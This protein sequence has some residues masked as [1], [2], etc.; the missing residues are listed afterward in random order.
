[1]KLAQ[2]NYARYLIW[3]MNQKINHN[4]TT[5]IP[6]TINMYGNDY[7]TFLYHFDYI[8]TSNLTTICDSPT[9]PE[10]VVHQKEKG[11]TLLPFNIKEWYR[12]QNQT[13]QCLKL[14]HHVPPDTNVILK[15]KICVE[16]GA[17]V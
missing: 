15:D 1:M 8:Y 17:V 4:I 13:K 16:T 3:V 2:F 10:K 11:L 14:L 7:E 9:C 5:N 6:T 12:G